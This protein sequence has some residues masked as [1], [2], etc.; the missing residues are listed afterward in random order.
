MSLILIFYFSYSLLCI[1]LLISFSS[2]YYIDFPPAQ[3]PAPT[4]SRLATTTTRT[5]VGTFTS[6]IARSTTR[7]ISCHKASQ[8]SHKNLSRIPTRIHL[9][10]CAHNR[11]FFT[12]LFSPSIA[13]VHFHHHRDVQQVSVSL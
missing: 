3:H 7:A 2:L 5:I 4:H 6:T 11:I 13:F 10:S 8:E 9:H 1:P 12:R